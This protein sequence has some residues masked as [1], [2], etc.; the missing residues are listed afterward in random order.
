MLNNT[1]FELALLQ[2]VLRPDFVS[3]MVKNLVIEI[4]RPSTYGKLYATALPPYLAKLYPR[5]KEMRHAGR[6]RWGVSS[7]TTRRAPLP[8]RS[9][10]TTSMVVV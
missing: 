1:E 9:L 8:T 6:I 7:S 4:A 5:V 3:F 2:E 10:S